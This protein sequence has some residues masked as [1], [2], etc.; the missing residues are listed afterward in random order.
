[1]ADDTVGS[2]YTQT[3]TLDYF[4]D[5]NERTVFRTRG[6]LAGNSIIWLA[7]ADSD[8]GEPM[9]LNFGHAGIAVEN[10]P[11]QDNLTTKLIYSVTDVIRLGGNHYT[12][13]MPLEDFDK[14]RRI[15]LATWQSKD[16]L[17]R[18]EALV[19]II[20]NYRAYFVL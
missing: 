14:S 4:N 12:L 9:H 16:G 13:L 2:I 7:I 6:Q 20:P 11:D 3:A 1:M 10:L 5:G 17:L 19:T 8:G 15:Y 18:R